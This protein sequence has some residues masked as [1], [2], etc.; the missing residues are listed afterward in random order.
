MASLAS[1]SLSGCATTRLAMTQ[2]P[3]FAAIL[4]PGSRGGGGTENFQRRE[5]ALMKNFSIAILKAAGAPRQLF[6]KLFAA[7]GRPR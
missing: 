3:R 4:W 1:Q 2:S 5:E 7:A 6:Q